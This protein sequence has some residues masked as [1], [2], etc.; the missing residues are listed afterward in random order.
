MLVFVCL[1]VC[2][3]VSLPTQD[4]LQQV[5]EENASLNSYLEQI[6]QELTEKAPALQK[7]RRDYD[8]CLQ[9]YEQVSQVC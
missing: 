5:R 2:L 8:L 7:L 4:E 6:E 1:S 3:S 9:N